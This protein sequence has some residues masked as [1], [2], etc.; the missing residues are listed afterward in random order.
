MRHWFSRPS[1]TLGYRLCGAVPLIAAIRLGEEYHTDGG[2]A[3]L[4]LIDNVMNEPKSKAT[5]N[6]A[7]LIVFAL[8]VAVVAILY[9]QVLKA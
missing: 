2:I 4:L 1:K 3:C 5:G 9:S 8:V 7:K 6:R